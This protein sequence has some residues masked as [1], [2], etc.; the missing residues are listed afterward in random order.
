M[1]IIEP[2][3]ELVTL[4]EFELYEKIFGD[5]I[6]LIVT[7][8]NKYASRMKNNPSFVLTREIFWNFCGLLLL[9]GYNM[10]TS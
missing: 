8:S 5:I 1:A 3:P 2:F 10:R 7:E 4:T 6:D 9:S